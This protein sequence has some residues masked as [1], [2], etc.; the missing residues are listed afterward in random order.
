MITCLL[1]LMD[2]RAMVVI[3]SDCC[4]HSLATSLQHDA[5]AVQDDEG[6]GQHRQ[7]HAGQDRVG[8]QRRHQAAF[9]LA[10]VSSTKPN[11]P[12]CAR[13]R[14]VRSD[15][16]VVAP[17]RARQQRDQRQLEQHRQ[18][19]QQHQQP[20]L[21]HRPPVEHMPM[22]MK[23]RPSS[24]SWKGRM[25]VSTWCLYSVS[26]ISMPAM[27][28]PSASD[29]PASSVSQA[30]PS[31]ISSRLRTNSSS[32]LRRATMVSHQRISAGR[33]R[34]GWRPGTPP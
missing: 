20:A 12:A 11:S 32:L 3:C 24:T 1:V 16:P 17:R 5:V 28:A 33:R 22:L 6:R 19:Q 34:A 29:R 4:S 2:L 27:K 8:S 15:T 26:E 18:H 31:V 23:N 14:P 13:Y 7:H 10:S 25:S 30:R 21:E 9:L